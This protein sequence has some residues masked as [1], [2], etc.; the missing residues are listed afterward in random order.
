M[1][2]FTSYIKP[3]LLIV[4]VAL[5]FIGTWLKQLPFVKNEYI[6]P[7]LGIIG[8]ILCAL[9]VFASCPLKSARNVSMAIF[10]SIVQG[11]VVAGVSTYIHQL[12]KKKTK[13]E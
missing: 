7:L 2:N 11:V 5:Y 10:V 6:P 8:I 1:E 9:W 4:S 13:P 3:E 12:L